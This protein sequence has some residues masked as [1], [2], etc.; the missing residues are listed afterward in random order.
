[1]VLHEDHFDVLYQEPEFP[2]G[3]EDCAL[4]K[5][6]AAFVDMVKIFRMASLHWMTFGLLISC[7]LL[8][9]Y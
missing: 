7:P 8:L 4:K 3:S 5:P 1:M 2:L 9:P 6:D